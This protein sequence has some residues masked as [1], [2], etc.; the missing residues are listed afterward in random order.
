[1]KEFEGKSKREIEKKTRVQAF[2]DVSLWL[3]LALVIMGGVAIAA[4]AIPGSVAELIPNAEAGYSLA[5]I[6]MTIAGAMLIASM[7]I[8]FHR[9]AMGIAM[10][11]IVKSWDKMAPDISM[12]RHGTSTG[13]YDGKVISMGLFCVWTKATCPDTGKPI[14]RRVPYGNLVNGEPVI[15]ALDADSSN[16]E[17]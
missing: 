13:Y 14:F 12:L 5:L 9:L 4:E 6:L 3:L 2:K 10:G 1:M 16:K 8:I 15:T 17:E 11:I 7:G